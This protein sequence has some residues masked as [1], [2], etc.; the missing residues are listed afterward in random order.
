MTSTLDKAQVN[1]RGFSLIELMVVVAI[2]GIAVA[3]ALPSYERYQRKAEISE[4]A[5]QLL[6][7][8]DRIREYRVKYGRYP[9]DSHIVPP[10]GVSMPAYWSETTT[11]GGTWN[12]EGPDRY[13]Y[14]GIAVY[15]HTADD[16]ELQ[17]MDSLVDDGNLST[18]MYR[19]GSN[20]R[21][22]YIIEDG[23]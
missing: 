8:A 14:A 19:W 20:G 5:S 3:I 17:I 21:P 12:W 13:A 2:I 23:I 16:D 18:G 7:M 1:I 22:V 10:P 4:A 9:N 6:T 11:L 15:Q